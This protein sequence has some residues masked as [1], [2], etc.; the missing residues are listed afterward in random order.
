[1]AIGL[2]EGRLGRVA[3]DLA[4][5]DRVG[6]GASDRGRADGGEQ[7]GSGKEA[8][9]IERGHARSHG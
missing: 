3:V 4:D 6:L 8:A 1:L 5:L 9:A 7:A 2:Q